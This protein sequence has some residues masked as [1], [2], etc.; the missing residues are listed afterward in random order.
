MPVSP[1][2]AIAAGK[3]VNTVPLCIVGA[4]YSASPAVPAEKPNVLFGKGFALFGTPFA[5]L[6]RKPASPLAATEIQ[7]MTTKHIRKAGLLAGLVLAGFSFQVQAAPLTYIVG[8]VTATLGYDDGNGGRSSATHEFS[9]ISGAET[10]NDYANAG[11]ALNG[12]GLD[13]TLDYSNLAPYFLD[14]GVTPYVDNSFTYTLDNT[15][16]Q[17]NFNNVSLDLFVNLLFM[18]PQAGYVSTAYTIG[19]WTLL[20]QDLLAGG[21][22]SVFSTTFTFSQDALSE[23][24]MLLGS[25]LGNGVWVT[26]TFAGSNT[27]ADAGLLGG[28]LTPFAEAQLLGNASFMATSVDVPE[29]GSLALL[30]LGLAALAAFQLRRRQGGLPLAA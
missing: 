13:S 8:L 29:P 5:I 28:G 25:S 17:Q 16:G 27:L 10:Q 9:P 30:A 2:R 15:N 6:H 26:A 4:L 20:L 19:N 14:D 1:R 21:S 12:S 18:A 3:T 24:S 7:V 11:A 22:Q 23:D